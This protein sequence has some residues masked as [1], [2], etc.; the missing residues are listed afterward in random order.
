M[1]MS[2]CIGIIQQVSLQVNPML[3]KMHLY[4][5]TTSFVHWVA[6]ANNTIYPL[7][8][9]WQRQPWSAWWDTLSLGSKG[10]K[11]QVLMIPSIPHSANHNFNQHGET[12]VQG[13]RAVSANNTIYRSFSQ[14]QLWPMQCVTLSLGSMD[15]K[16]WVLMTPSL[17]HPVNHNFKN[18]WVTL[19]LGSEDIKL[20]VLMTSSITH[21]ANHNFNQQG[22]SLFYSVP[23]TIQKINLHYHHTT[24]YTVSEYWIRVFWWVIDHA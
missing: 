13:C 3:S 4:V 21:S 12:I 10:I 19:S 8:R 1:E 20:Q 9:Q 16:P 11:L 5:H 17:T 22:E 14:P 15:V 23:R 24:V 2:T 7:F 6:S 18:Q